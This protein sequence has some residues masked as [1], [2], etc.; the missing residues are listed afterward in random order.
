MQTVASTSTAMRT[1]REGVVAGHWSAA[2]GAYRSAVPVSDSAMMPERRKAPESTGEDRRPE[3]VTDHHAADGEQRRGVVDPEVR[4]DDR[5][6]AH[7][8]EQQPQQRRPAQP[9]AAGDEGDDDAGER[10]PG[11]E[12]PGQRAGQPLLGGG[13]QDPRDR[14]LDGRERDD[15]P[16]PRQHRAKVHAEQ[17]DRQQE[18]RRRSPYGRTPARPV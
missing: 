8:P 16:P 18:R 2:T 9:I 12:Q 15:P 10:R 13:Q 5:D 4:A 17:C 6:D 7:Q 3:R 11:D 1:S 14:D